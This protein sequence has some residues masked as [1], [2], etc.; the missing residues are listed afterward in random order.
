MREVKPGVA[1]V[2]VDWMVSGIQK[3]EADSLKEMMKGVFTHT[4]VKNN[5]KWEITSSQNTLIANR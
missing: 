4:L 5:D 1:I 2:R 3:S